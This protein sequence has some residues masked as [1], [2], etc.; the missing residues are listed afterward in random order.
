MSITLAATHC[1]PL[2][3]FSRPGGRNRAQYYNFLPWHGGYAAVQQG[4]FG[5]GLMA[6]NGWRQWIA[7]KWSMTATAAFRQMAALETTDADRR[8]LY[9][10]RT[11]STYGRMAEIASLSAADE[12]QRFTVV[13]RI[14]IGAGQPRSGATAAGRHQACHQR[15]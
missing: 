12:P 9:T 2:L 14:L 10:C 8:T 3:N 15:I 11:R 1:L 5:H 6:E 13:Q 7:S 4:L